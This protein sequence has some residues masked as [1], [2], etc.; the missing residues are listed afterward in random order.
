MRKKLHYVILAPLVLLMIGLM[1]T[2]PPGRAQAGVTAGATPIAVGTYTPVLIVAQGDKDQLIV[3]NTGAHPA[4]CVFGAGGA[5]T[6]SGASG[7]NYN[8][9]IPNA[10]QTTGGYAPGYWVSPTLQ[11]PVKLGQSRS[12]PDAMYCVAPGGAI[13]MQTYVR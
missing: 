12:I 11:L 9:Q 4:D 3:T 6:T 5:G 13:T 10:T 2:H 1:I 8:I 7:T